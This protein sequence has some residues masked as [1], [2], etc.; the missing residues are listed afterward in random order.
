MDV[1][2][3]SVFTIYMCKKT[4]NYEIVWEAQKDFSIEGGEEMVLSSAAV[5]LELKHNLQLTIKKI[6]ANI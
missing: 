1:S 2:K 6:N 3:K 4:A 5:L